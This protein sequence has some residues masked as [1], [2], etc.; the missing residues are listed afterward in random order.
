MLTCCSS[1]CLAINLPWS[2]GASIESDMTIKNPEKFAQ[3]KLIPQYLDKSEKFFAS[4]LNDKSLDATTISRQKRDAKKDK[5]LYDKVQN[6]LEVLSTVKERLIQLIQRLQLP[7]GQAFYDLYKKT[8]FDNIKELKDKSSDPY[9]ILKIDKIDE[10]RD[11]LYRFLSWNLP[12]QKSVAQIRAMSYQDICTA[13]EEIKNQ[14]I[15]KGLGNSSFFKLV[16]EIRAF[17]DN[18]LAKEQYDAFVDGPEACRRLVVSDQNVR[19]ALLKRAKNFYEQMYPDIR[20]KLL[21]IN[22]FFRK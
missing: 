13:I 4:I 3:G 16:R 2:S 18:E 6:K 7:T 20:M 19:E 5:A 8:Y 11:C 15:K 17:F 22:G 1:L 10:N 9:N 21:E 12:E 14:A